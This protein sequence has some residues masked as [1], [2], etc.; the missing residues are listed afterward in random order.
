M[1]LVEIRPAVRRTGPIRLVPLA[2]VGS[3]T[4]FR[5]VFCYPTVTVDTIMENKSTSYL[6]G[7]PVYCDTLLVDFDSCTGERMIQHLL[8]N[9]I[10][11]D[12]YHSGG[13]SIHLH[14]PINPIEGPWVP[15]ACKQWVKN[16]DR[17]ADV[18][19][20]TMSGQFRLPGTFHSKN[21]GGVKHLLQSYPGSKLTIEQPEQ[22]ELAD[23]Q[24][25]GTDE[26]VLI[27][28]TKHCA[29]GHR[30]PHAWRIATCAAEAGWD[31][32]RALDAV[33]QWNDKFCTPPHN[34]QD[35]VSQVEKSYKRHLH[36]YG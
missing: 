14:V 28:A 3:H 26:A 18:S 6:R 9:G 5:S 1:Y 4:G 12:K 34:A 7:L 32:D 20:Y 8:D 19:Y 25:T 16:T 21:L 36:R 23:M 31:F 35:L 15:E 30:R 27:A 33:V 10:G 13:R 22:E 24:V 11:F 17:T 29:E 2:D